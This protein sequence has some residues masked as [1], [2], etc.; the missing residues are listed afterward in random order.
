MNPHRA[1]NCYRL[2]RPRSRP[3][4]LTGMVISGHIVRLQLAEEIMEQDQNIKSKRGSHD[5]WWK[6]HKCKVLNHP[7]HHC[8]WCN[9]PPPSP[10]STTT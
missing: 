2:Y 9:A 10:L 1:R 4:L 5:G 3:N 6:C 8:A 7:T